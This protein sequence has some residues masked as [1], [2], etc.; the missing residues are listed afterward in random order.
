MLLNLCNSSSSS[1]LGKLTFDKAVQHRVDFTA[2]ALAVSDVASA[3]GPRPC[4]DTVTRTAHDAELLVGVELPTLR[5]DVG[6]H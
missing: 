2:L 3:S 4:P 1:D 6:C 5:P